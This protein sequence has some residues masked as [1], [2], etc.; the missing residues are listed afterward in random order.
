MKLL[1][2]LGLAGVAT[3]HLTA[4]ECPQD[5]EALCITDI[6]K[7]YP[8]CEKAAQEKGKDLP[9]DLEC[10]KYFTQIEKDCW[11]CICFFAK[12][13][14]WNI[15]GCK[16]D[17]FFMS[18]KFLFSYIS[19]WVVVSLKRQIAFRKFRLVYNDNCRLL[20]WKLFL[21]YKR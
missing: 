13:A 16:W 5:L 1:A 6:N 12:T 9:A 17:S 3:A 8:I 11:P 18:S 7:A 19:I 21:I 20:K 2:L 10:M 15:K 14:G 4:D